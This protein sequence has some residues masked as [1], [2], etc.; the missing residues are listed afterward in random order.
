MYVIY[1]RTQY[2]ISK[3]ESNRSISNQFNYASETR[4]GRELKLP[5]N[6]ALTC[7]KLAIIVLLC[8]IKI[9]FFKER[10][11][12]GI[13]HIQLNERSKKKT[14]HAKNTE[15]LIKKERK[16]NS[17]YKTLIFINIP[18]NDNHSF[19]VFFFLL[20]TRLITNSMQS[21]WFGC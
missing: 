19:N 16:K 5:I 9:V 3:Q 11:N 20:L 17:L 6:G 15:K 8:R 13:K 12:Y 14:G 10:V 21:L 18:L 2:L 1:F 4:A 7:S